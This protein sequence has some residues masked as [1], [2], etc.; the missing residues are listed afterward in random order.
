MKKGPTTLAAIAL[1]ALT[2]LAYLGFDLKNPEPSIPVASPYAVVA[3]TVAPAEPS[4]APRRLLARK[5]V[6]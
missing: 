4:P 2:Y 5:A 6:K 3:N 1:G